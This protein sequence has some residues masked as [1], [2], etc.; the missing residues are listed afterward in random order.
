VP[1]SDVGPIVIPDGIDDDKVL[2]LSDILPTGWQAAENA[3]SRTATPSPFWGCGPV[4]LFAI[5]SAFK[6]GAHRVI[7]IDHYPRR[8]QLGQADGRRHPRLSRR[9]RCSKR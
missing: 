4:G 5:Q 2:F 8:L 6:L 7:A 3:T 9:S 1:F